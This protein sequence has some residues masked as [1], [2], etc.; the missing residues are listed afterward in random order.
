MIYNTQ[1]QPFPEAG[2]L[3]ENMNRDL[4]TLRQMLRTEDGSLYAYI[5]D[6]IQYDGNIFCQTGSGPNFQGDVITLCSC[7]HQMRSGLSVGEWPGVWIAGFTGV[8][9]VGGE[10]LNYLVYLMKV[11][12]AYASHRDLWGKL[13]VVARRVKAAHLHPLGDLYQPNAK[14]GGRFDPR[15]YEPPRSDHS[16]C[17]D[18]G[19]HTDIDYTGYGGRRPPLLVGDRRF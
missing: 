19:W 3:A 14:G 2:I 18:N 5:V 6:T 17:H 7:K 1:C 12:N 9:K 13:P 15:S 4:P 16:H 8:G 11:A 10:P